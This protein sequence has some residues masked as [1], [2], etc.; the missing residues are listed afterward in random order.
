MKTKEIV[1]RNPKTWEK[2]KQQITISN[3][4]HRVEKFTKEVEAVRETFNVCENVVSLFD[5]KVLKY[6]KYLED[7]KSIVLELRKIASN[8]RPTLVIAD[9]GAGKTHAFFN[10]TTEDEWNIGIFPYWSM[11]DH[12]SHKYDIERM[13]GGDFANFEIEVENRVEIFEGVFYGEDRREIKASTVN[14]RFALLMD[15]ADEMQRYIEDLGKNGLDLFSMRGVVWVDEA[16][17]LVSSS[18]RKSA[19]D[20]V[21][22]FLH[23]IMHNTGLSVIYT[24]ATPY[25]C[26]LLPFCDIKFFDKKEEVSN[27]KK[28]SEYIAKDG[29]NVE[30]MVVSHINRAIKNNKK[31]IL[32]LN[33]IHTISNIKH[34]FKNVDVITGQNKGESKIF[35]GISENST[36]DMSETDILALTCVLDAG[37]S[38]DKVVGC[39]VEDIVNLFVVD[40]HFDVNELKQFSNRLRFNTELTLIVD[41]HEDKSDYDNH[42]FKTFLETAKE[43][44]EKFGLYDKNFTLVYSSL[45]NIYKD[46]NKV[47]Q[48]LQSILNERDYFG[49]RNDLDGVY[50]IDFKTKEFKYDWFKAF[51]RI[52]DEYQRQYFYFDDIREQWLT[53]TFLVDEI[54]REEIEY[55]DKYVDIVEMQ[56]DEFLNNV[57]SDL[58]LQ[59][60]IK[61]ND[62]KEIKKV[63]KEKYNLSNVDDILE[64]KKYEKLQVLIKYEK[65]VSNAIKTILENTPIELGKIIK[66]YEREALKNLTKQEL[67]MIS[68]YINEK[69]LDNV[70]DKVL[71]IINS[72]FIEIYEDAQSLGIALDTIQNIINA[73]G[74]KDAKTYIREEIIIQN[75][76]KY[77]KKN[78]CNGQAA[79]EQYLVINHIEANKS[80]E[81]LNV[82]EELMGKITKVLTKKTGKKWTITD[83]E[84]FIKEIYSWTKLG[85]SIKV[86]N[87]RTKHSA[88]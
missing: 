5:N 13:C 45:M 52:W 18:F 2:E 40:E 42:A 37:V 29:Q 69:N 55:N 12:N 11:T 1:V 74:A 82:N 10:I 47:A 7:N 53:S 17:L 58:D 77:S 76:I 57:S 84:K 22:N 26:H 48:H 41:K 64:S 33:N 75:N 15:K 54:T 35:K 66:D 85:K 28:V 46:N 62:T 32:R 16:H 61:K 34:T 6:D 80:G 50:T 4:Q 25:N 38:I 72:D 68:A 21:Q 14:K 36:L 86:K 87:L 8:K 20:K 71:N 63:L 60:V 81:T 56:V 49:Q 24:T 39:E 43:K 67:G 23:F 70:N 3:Y 78:K 73:G 19:I 79:Y 30:D 59:Y 9:T 27:I 65:N 44:G 88:K 83:T 51:N 31:V